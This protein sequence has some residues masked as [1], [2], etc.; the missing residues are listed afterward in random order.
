VDTYNPVR[1]A[2]KAFNFIKKTVKA[3]GRST[4]VPAGKKK[5][6]KKKSK[7]EAQ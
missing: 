7:K 2:T 5:M 4:A 6:K 1:V 3:T